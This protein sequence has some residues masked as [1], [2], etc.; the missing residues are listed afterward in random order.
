MGLPR[1]WR[2]TRR[3]CLG[4]DSWLTHPARRGIPTGQRVRPGGLWRPF[5]LA[6]MCIQPRPSHGT[7]FTIGD[8]RCPVDLA[9]DFQVCRISRGRGAFS[10]RSF[11]TSFPHRA[12][13]EPSPASWRPASRL[14]GTFQGQLF[15]L[16]GASPRRYAPRAHRLLVQ[17]AAFSTHSITTLRGAP[18]SRPPLHGWGIPP[19][20]E[21]SPSVVPP[22]V[23]H[24]RTRMV[25]PRTFYTDLNVLLWLLAEWH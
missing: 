17:A 13:S 1:S 6:A 2:W 23:A 22:C 10:R 25:Y 20:R 3:E 16:S 5:W 18:E 21:D 14:T 12:L 15:H 8:G 7:L 19:T 4:G 24:C 9:Q 11:V